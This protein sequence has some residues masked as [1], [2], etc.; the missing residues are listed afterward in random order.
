MPYPSSPW[1]P[2][3]DPSAQI[4]DA[5]SAAIAVRS[6]TQRYPLTAGTLV[7]E[8]PR[9]STYHFCLVN[10]EALP[11]DE[12]LVLES[13]DIDH[14]LQVEIS[15]L[16]RTTVTLV[17]TQRLLER[18]LRQATLLVDHAWLLRH[19]KETLE[20]QL[21][22]AQIEPVLF[23][24]VAP[25]DPI[26]A[27]LVDVTIEKVLEGV[28]APDSYQ[29]GAIERALRE[30][31]LLVMGPPGTGKTNVLA[32]IALAHLLR[33]SA[34][35]ILI[36]AHTNIALDNAIE[37]LVLFCQKAGEQPLL[38]DRKIIRVGTPRLAALSG[39]AYTSVVLP[40]IIEEELVSTRL[41]IER[42][43]Q[44]RDQLRVQRVANQ[45][46]EHRLD[47][48]WSK[49]RD[50]LDAQITALDTQVADVRRRSQKA[51]TSLRRVVATQTQ[52]LN[53]AQA[54]VRLMRDGAGVY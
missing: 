53:D 20:R 25:H 46:E 41:D 45:R 49:E 21:P 28:F 42:I 11:A 14:P 12:N 5:L 39:A 43:E 36:L 24:M 15:D 10:G 34:P 29:R 48:A 33:R 17:V 38:D 40:L 52:Q 3:T 4:L 23:G 54:Y 50:R 16:T 51:H 31:L 18:T 19:L 7:E 35:R 13:A 30:E 32:A 8:R 26:L 1:S 22:A 9:H 37:R 27:H 2:G 44:K 47:G 6:S